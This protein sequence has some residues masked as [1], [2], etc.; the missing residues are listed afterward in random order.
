V[1]L[2]RVT[3]YLSA[4][5]F[6]YTISYCYYDNFYD[7]IFAVKF[8]KTFSLFLLYGSVIIVQYLERPLIAIS[9]I[10]PIL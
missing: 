9:T 1:L 8:L 2:V 6:I 7:L 3:V 10:T 5:L 4:N